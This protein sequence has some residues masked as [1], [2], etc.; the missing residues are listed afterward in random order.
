MN[1]ANIVAAALFDP[2]GPA[3][4]VLLDMTRETARDLFALLFG[5]A[6]LARVRAARMGVIVAL[7]SHDG[8]SRIILP[9]RSAEEIQF[10]NSHIRNAEVAGLAVGYRDL[11][12]EL[13]TAMQNA[14][15]AMV[16][17]QIPPGGTA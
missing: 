10:I 16:L 11:D 15:A 2:D 12:P 17:E 9:V 13:L 6:E 5:D 7:K 14:E 1:T 3:S 8:E 4:A